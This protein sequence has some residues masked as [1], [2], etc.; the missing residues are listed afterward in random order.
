MFCKTNIFLL[1]SFL[2]MNNGLVGQW[3]C[4]RWITVQWLVGHMIMMDKKGKAK[5]K[6][7][8]DENMNK[9]YF[10]LKLI[11]KGYIK[12]LRQY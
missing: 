8:T 2:N 4:G 9:V 11:R 7:Q 12:D 10:P 5:R 6:T 1:P 3:V